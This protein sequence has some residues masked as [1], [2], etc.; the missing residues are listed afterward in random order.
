MTLRGAF[1]VAAMVVA[2]IAALVCF[3]AWASLAVGIGL[4]AVAVACYAAA[5]VPV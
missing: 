2:I 4:L 5:A 3:F 1:I